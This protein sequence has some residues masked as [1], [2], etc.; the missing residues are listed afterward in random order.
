MSALLHDTVDDGIVN[1]FQF[2]AFLFAV[3]D[4]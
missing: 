1:A 4:D 2:L 3:I